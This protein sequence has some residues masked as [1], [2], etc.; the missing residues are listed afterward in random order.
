MDLGN[1]LLTDL[2]LITATDQAAAIHLPEILKEIDRVKGRR[3]V[4]TNQDFTPK[5]LKF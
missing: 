1:A 5:N 2:G 3:H 4:M